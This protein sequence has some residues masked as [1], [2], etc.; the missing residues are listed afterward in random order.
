MGNKYHPIIFAGLSIIMAI[1]FFCSPAN[2]A[3]NSQNLAIVVKIGP[4]ADLSISNERTARSTS[5]N[6]SI[7]STTET[8]G[9]G[10]TLFIDG[11]VVRGSAPLNLISNDAGG[12]KFY[13][14]INP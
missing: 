8:N 2:A 10:G 14:L 4:R 5:N 7:V 3:N 11:T 6:K 1:L 13:T 12:V 9:F